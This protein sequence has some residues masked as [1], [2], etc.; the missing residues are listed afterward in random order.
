MSGL[1]KQQA[2]AQEIAR[3]CQHILELA[4]DAGVYV[5]IKITEAPAQ[6]E[7]KDAK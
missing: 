2:A 4:P 3:L 5:G 7:R 1:T 6:I